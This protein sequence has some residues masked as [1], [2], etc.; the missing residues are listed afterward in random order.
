MAYEIG[1]V[2]N[3]GGL[4][5]NQNMLLKIKTFAEANG[6]TTLRYDDTIATRE[7]ILKSL[8]LSGTEEIFIGFRAYQDVGAD[9]YNI[10]VAGFTGYVPGNSFIT[11]P[12]YFESGIPAHNLSIG[13]WLR[14]T[15]NGIYFALKVGTP[16]YTVGIAAKA[17]PIALPTQYP[18]PLV[19][20]G[21]LSGVP[22]TRYSDTTQSIPFK[23]D[24]ANLKM[25]FVN[26]TWMQPFAWPWTSSHIAGSTA[27]LRETGTVYPLQ[28][29]T[30][31]NNG[32]STYG[33]IDGVYHISGFNN[34]VENTLTI[35]GKLYVVVQDV[36][37]TSFNDYIALEMS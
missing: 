23:G 25:R 34:V 36:Y 15:A 27:Q 9:Y 37:R 12:G 33:V 20:G 26:G 30:L 31:H 14:S 22:A 29:I 1:T 11:Q 35:G 13:Y 19:V 10:S 24:R 7:L 18:Y 2:T 28:P 3:S 5:A 16:V 6:W 8:G 4:Y 21:M 17:L 32:G